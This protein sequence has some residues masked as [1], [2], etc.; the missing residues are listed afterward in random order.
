MNFKY[1]R[2]VGRYRDME[3]MCTLQLFDSTVKKQT[4]TIRIIIKL[5][6]HIMKK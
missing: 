5:I 1:D 2:G 4:K 6:S 3:R